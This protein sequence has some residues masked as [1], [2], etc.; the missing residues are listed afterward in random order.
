MPL[1]SRLGSK[2]AA[3]VAAFLLIGT[4]GAQEATPA[5]PAA[6]PQVNKMTIYKGS[7]PTV[8]YSV[9]GASPHLQA[10]F[11]TLQY[12][13]NEIKLTGELQKLRLGIVANEQTLDSLRTWQQLGLGPISAPSYAGYSAPPDALKSA[14]IPGLAREATPATA[15]ALI[16]LKEQVQ[17][18]LQA[19][20][21]KAAVEVRGEPPAGQNAQPAAPVAVTVAV[22]QGAPVA[23]PV[24]AKPAAPVMVAA[25]TVPPQPPIPLDPVALQ[26]TVRQNQA[27]A[28][29]QTL[30]ALQP[31]LQW[32]PVVMQMH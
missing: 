28:R 27:R 1:L 4:A 14:L 2:M 21:A 20:Q 31:I 11:Q 29:Q 17:T 8:S 15:Y 22:P 30:Q 25:Q 26:Q 24:A 32:H 7:V 13:E 6:G 12:T 19:E 5:A 18:E 9:Q 16:N 3:L 23:G 10:L